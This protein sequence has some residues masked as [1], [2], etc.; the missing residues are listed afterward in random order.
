MSRIRPLSIWLRMFNE[1]LS[2]LAT[3]S[4]PLLP[5]NP[6]RAS[7]NQIAPGLGP[8]RIV[9]D[10]RVVS[11][12][13][14]FDFLTGILLA[15]EPAGHATAARPGFVR[16]RVAVFRFH[17]APATF[18]TITTTVGVGR[19]TTSLFRSGVAQSSKLSHKFG[20]LC[21]ARLVMLAV[22]PIQRILLLGEG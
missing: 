14:L 15:L 22:H 1:R 16:L 17:L 21:R 12:E 11:D 2:Q 6:A 9:L 13:I 19:R 7:P 3:R 18:P 8:G 10:V 20:P 5:A 4:A